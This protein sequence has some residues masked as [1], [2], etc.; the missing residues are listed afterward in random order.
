MQCI[1]YRLTE[2]FLLA[3]LFFCFA[4]QASGEDFTVNGKEY[5]D[6]TVSRIEPDGLVLKTKSGISKVYFTEL[7]KEVQKRYGYDPQK[8]AE[9]NNSE[10]AAVAKSNAATVPQ[11]PVASASDEKEHDVELTY[12]SPEELTAKERA[13]AQAKMLS[14][15]EVDRELAMI[16]PGGMIKVKL[17]DMVIGG[18]NPKWLTYI[19]TDSAGQVLARGNGSDRIPEVKNGWRWVGF[20]H[21]D[22]PA[23]TDSLQLRV[24]HNNWGNLGDF[25]ITRTG[26]VQ[27]K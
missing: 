12:V 17:Y 2:G 18:A 7:P 27:R 6:A 4:S 11:Q 10:R 13:T 21:I 24:Y 5:K 16:P 1:R 3:F 20:D 25:T 23:F 26:S 14:N 22:L 9:F 8:A 19:I 15:E